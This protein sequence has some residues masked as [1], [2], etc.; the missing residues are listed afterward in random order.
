MPSPTGTTAFPS[1]SFSSFSSGGGG[2]TPTFSFSIGNA[3]FASSLVEGR[4]AAAWCTQSGPEG[5]EKGEAAAALETRSGATAAA[6]RKD[7]DTC[8]VREATSPS[9]PNASR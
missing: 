3:G 1:S 4:W 5:G 7:G 8:V 2:T 9:W 6:S